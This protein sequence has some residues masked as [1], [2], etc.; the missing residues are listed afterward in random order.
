MSNKLESNICELLK[1]CEELIKD[2]N[3]SWRLKKYIKSLDDMIKDL[4]NLHK[5][6][7]I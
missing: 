7:Y 6:V 1:Q 2:N 5:Y 4:D 3:Y